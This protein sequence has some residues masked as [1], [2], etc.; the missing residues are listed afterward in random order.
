[1]FYV[2][3]TQGEQEDWI[4]AIFLYL[5]EAVAYKDKMKEENVL[6]LDNIHIA[7]RDYQGLLSWLRLYD[8]DNENP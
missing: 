7:V 8:P 4:Q 5:E 6:G 1:M 3:F 2:A